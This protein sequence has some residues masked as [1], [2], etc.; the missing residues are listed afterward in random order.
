[1]L[2]Y[3]YFLFFIAVNSASF[4]SNYN[5][6]LIDLENKGKSL[7]HYT[8]HNEEDSVDFVSM[9]KPKTKEQMYLFISNFQPRQS[10][11]HDDSHIV[12]MVNT[13]HHVIMN[14]IYHFNLSVG[15]PIEKQLFSLFFRYIANNLST[16]LVR[17]NKLEN[18][19]PILSSSC[20]VYNFDPSTGAFKSATP[21]KNEVRIFIP[22]K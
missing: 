18:E 12:I 14:Q 21:F 4:S 1:M 19:S 10:A 16:L 15:T 13:E 22:P 9:K 8:K 20:W 17:Y 2:V 6:T 3:F 5:K 11:K 7:N